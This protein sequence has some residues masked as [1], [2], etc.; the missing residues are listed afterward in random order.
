MFIN[1]LGRMVWFRAKSV[2]CVLRENSGF[3]GF[4]SV[5][6]DEELAWGKRRNDK[7]QQLMAGRERCERDRE[8][9]ELRCHGSP[10]VKADLF[11]FKVITEILRKEFK[12]SLIS[13]VI[14][15]LSFSFCLMLFIMS[16]SS[17]QVAVKCMIPSFLRAV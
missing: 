5:K 3:R 13:D 1:S 16:S 11:H 9:Y 17:V 6:F 2:I 15:Y 14:L 8:S 7:R 4:T 10:R 12:I